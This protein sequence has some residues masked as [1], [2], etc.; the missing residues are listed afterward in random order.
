[1]PIPSV[2]SIDRADGS[3][4]FTS[5]VDIA[6]YTIR[7]LS[8]RALIDVGRY[9]SINVRKRLI[10]H[11]P[12]AGKRKNSLRY[13]YWVLKREC[14]LLLGI[15]N[16]TKGAVTAWWA[17]QLE[18]DKFA[19]P[20]VT[21]WKLKQ[22]QEKRAT[23]MEARYMYEHLDAQGYKAWLKENNLKNA[24]KYRTRVRQPKPLGTPNNPRRHILETFAK[25]HIDTI[26]EIESQ[27]LSKINDEDAAIALA[28][29]TE[30]MEVL[31][32]DEN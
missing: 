31:R 6:K 17:D 29:A 18:L 7:E 30:E 15:Q 19:V 27:Y 12:F 8:R 4:T 14:W 16:V 11:F 32:G 5:K 20:K 13:G 28:Q 2:V 9:V 1:M 3:V 25:T 10:A 21:P 26:I 22:A 23:T 24:A